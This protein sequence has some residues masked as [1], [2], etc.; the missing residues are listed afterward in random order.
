MKEREEDVQETLSVASKNEVRIGET[1]LK[2]IKS[3]MVSGV[4][5]ESMTANFAFL[6]MRLFAGIALAFQHGIK[7]IPPSPKFIET[8][9]GFGFPIPEVFAWAAG[10]SELLGGL[11]L[12]VGVGTRPASLFI[13]ITMS[14]AVFFRHASDPF[15]QKELAILYATIS[16]CFLLVGS[17]RFGIDD[18]LRRQSVPQKE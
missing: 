1:F 6:V 8:V 18:F 13:L 17:G 7:K 2:R 11:C 3:L 5:V 10:F 9:T 14:V 12:V 4:N 15:A 16:F